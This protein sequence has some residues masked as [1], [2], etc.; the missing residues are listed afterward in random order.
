[1]VHGIH[2]FDGSV[3]SP[4]SV[5]HFIP[6]HCELRL[7]GLIF[8]DSQA[9]ISNFLRS[10]LKWNILRVHPAYGG[11]KKGRQKI[12]LPP[13]QFHGRRMAS[14]VKGMIENLIN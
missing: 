8:P 13:L 7:A 6:H 10:R 14:I 4:V 5:L 9:L 3:K 12:F 2:N 1:M 11:K